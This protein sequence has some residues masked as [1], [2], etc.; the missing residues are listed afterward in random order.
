ML[1]N[2]QTL[3]NVFNLTGGLVAWLKEEKK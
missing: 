2:H 1:P 3:K